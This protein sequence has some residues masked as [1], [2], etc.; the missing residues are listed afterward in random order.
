MTSA[1][2]Q[3]HFPVI[4]PDHVDAATGRTLTVVP[5]G[6]YDVRVAP[7][8]N[9]GLSPVPGDGRWSVLAAP[10]EQAPEDGLEELAEDPPVA[11]DDPEPPPAELA[12]ESEP[13]TT[14]AAGE[15]AASPESEA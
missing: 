13:E 6:I 12:A 5:G 9:P 11:P 2:Y 14:P 7:G 3:G 10:A 8:R 1:Q 15:A 4:Y